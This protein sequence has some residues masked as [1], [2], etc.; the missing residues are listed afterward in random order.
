MYFLLQLWFALETGNPTLIL[1]NNMN[2]GAI[3]LKDI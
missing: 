3:L 2:N 1:P